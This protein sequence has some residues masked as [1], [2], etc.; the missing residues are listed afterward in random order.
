[1]R[2]D[3][4]LKNFLS[5]ARGKFIMIPGDYAML[6]ILKIVDFK[7]LEIQENFPKF[8]KGDIGKRTKYNLTSVHIDKWQHGQWTRIQQNTAIE[9]LI[10]N[11]QSLDGPGGH[12]EYTEVLVKEVS[13]ELFKTFTN[14]KRDESTESVYSKT[15]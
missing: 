7:I 13:A 10:D 9:Y 12:L 1:M 4:N 2:I 11:W 3:H 5:K 6:T 8:F 14:E 15:D